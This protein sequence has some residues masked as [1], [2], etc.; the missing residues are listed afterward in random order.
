M[1]PTGPAWL[2]ELFY[3]LALRLMAYRTLYLLGEVSGSF[4]WGVRCREARFQP[5]AKTAAPSR[6]TV[7]GS[8]TVVP[9]E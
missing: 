8:G 7:D 4:N 6:A 9:T 3:V 1:T 2:R 5:S